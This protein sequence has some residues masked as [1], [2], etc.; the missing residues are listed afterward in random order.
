MPTTQTR[1]D[2]STE[3]IRHFRDAIRKELPAQV[4]FD[5]FLGRR[6]LTPLS[7]IAKKFGFHTHQVK[8]YADKKPHRYKEM[9]LHYIGKKLY[10][11]I[12]IFTEWALHNDTMRR[13]IVYS[14]SENIVPV[15]KGADLEVLLNQGKNYLLDDLCSSGIIPQPFTDVNGKGTLIQFARNTE[16]PKEEIGLWFDEKFNAWV[17]SPSRFF[18]FLGTRL[19]I[20]E[21]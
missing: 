1:T 15:S 18:K 13:K 8:E 19:Q 5:F 2:I 6:Q 7:E 4:N 16:H 3:D 9:G 11:N 17:V 21:N 20:F 12:K 10:A 14:F